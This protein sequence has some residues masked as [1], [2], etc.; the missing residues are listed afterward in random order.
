MK[1]DSLELADKRQ[2]ALDKVLEKQ[3]KADNGEAEPEN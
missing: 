3:M 1:N 2:E